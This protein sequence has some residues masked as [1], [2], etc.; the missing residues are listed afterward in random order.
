MGPE[1]ASPLGAEATAV[2]GSEDRPAPSVAPA[3]GG[4][5]PTALELGATATLEG[6]GALEA[7]GGSVTVG[8]AGA[9]G[10]GAAGVEGAGCVKRSLGSGR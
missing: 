8:A 2:E 1:A 3:A 4:E 7:A 6:D 10:G 9:G 5:A